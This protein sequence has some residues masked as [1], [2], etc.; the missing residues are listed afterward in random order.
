[1]L[2]IVDDL[3]YESANAQNLHGPITTL[4]KLKSHPD[5][6]LYILREENQFLNVESSLDDVYNLDGIQ[7]YNS[8]SN[9]DKYSVVGMI[10]VGV[11]NLFIV[12]WKSFY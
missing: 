1:M 4:A 7:G 6:R 11:K 10:K 3:G 8:L 5:H 2:A 9:I 12:V